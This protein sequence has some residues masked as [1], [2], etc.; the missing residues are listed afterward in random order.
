MSWRQRLDRYVN[1][2][3]CP[4]ISDPASILHSSATRMEALTA[5][6]ENIGLAA[7]NSQYTRSL[8]QGVA[9]RASHDDPATGLA[10]LTDK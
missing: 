4:D 10:C 1:K 8:D 3:P 2:K 7:V 5:L 6:P 9:D